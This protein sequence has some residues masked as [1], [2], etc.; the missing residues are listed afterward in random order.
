ASTT[1]WAALVCRGATSYPLRRASR[2]GSTLRFYH[3]SQGRGGAAT[4]GDVQPRGVRCT[5][6]LD[7]RQATG[8]GHGQRPAHLQERGGSVTHE[9]SP[10]APP[11]RDPRG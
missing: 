11:A 5:T 9:R 6:R 3:R 2:K 7:R 1:L 4:G 8:R 10:S